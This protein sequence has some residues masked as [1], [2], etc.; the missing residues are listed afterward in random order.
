M[1][2]QVGVESADEF[3]KYLTNVVV[4]TMTVAWLSLLF[5]RSIDAKVYKYRKPFSIAMTLQLF[6]VTLRNLSTMMLSSGF[7]IPCQWVAVIGGVIYQL[8]A[9]SAECA[10]LIRCRSFTRYPRAVT[11]LTIPTWIVRFGLCL[12]LVTTI[13]AE[14]NQAGYICDTS[15]DYNLSAIMQYIKIATEVII[16]VFFLERVIAL[17]RSSRGM[18]ADSNHNQWR[19]LALINAGITFLVILFEILVG[20]VTVYLTGYLFLTYSLVNFIQA[21]LVVFIVEDTKNVFKKRAVTSNSASKQSNSR[22]HGQN[23]SQRGTAT[24]YEHSTVSYADGIAAAKA[25]RI[26]EPSNH[27][28][29]SLTMRMPSALPDPVPVHYNSNERPNSNF[30]DFGLSDQKINPYR[31]WEVDAESQDTIDASNRWRHNKD[32]D[33]IPM[34]L[35]RIR[36]DPQRR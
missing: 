12:W 6:F 10:M 21:T 1:P 19:R 13:K 16:L 26:H 27:Q 31:H 34:T 22:S 29:W 3:T 4:V 11:Y 36:E 28:P 24:D 33:E 5:V 9:I 25:N 35:S 23:S 32:E 20:Q 14:D 18:E 2:F 7:P 17:H 30:Y 8:F 15:M